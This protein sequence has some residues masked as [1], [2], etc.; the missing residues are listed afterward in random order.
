MAHVNTSDRKQQRSFGL[1]MAVAICILGM[2]RWW[3]H[4]YG[5]LPYPFFCVAGVFAA[6]GLIAP[7]VLK[8]VLIVW[9]KF[10]EVM[11][12]IM[13]RIMLTMAFFLMIVPIRYCIKLFSSD[14][15]NRV[16]DPTADSYWEEPE[17]QPEELERYL[18]Q[19]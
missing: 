1:I 19:F 5:P 17:E 12:W 2:I 3:L 6:L 13:T 16:W 15:L 10:G 18:N 7:P 4:G 11:N 9:L 14:P 8:P